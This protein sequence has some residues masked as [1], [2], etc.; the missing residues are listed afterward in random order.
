MATLPF[1]T[2]EEIFK[3]I[4]KLRKDLNPDLDGLT[5]RQMVVI[6]AK[7]EAMEKAEAQ[8]TSASM[9]KTPGK[10]KEFKLDEKMLTAEEREKT[11]K[12][13]ANMKVYSKEIA[14]LNKANEAQKKFSGFAYQYLLRKAV[15]IIDLPAA[16]FKSKFLDMVGRF[17]SQFGI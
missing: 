5:K 1:M 7:L 2:I 6:L 4:T 11:D 15:E 10:R 9:E 16:E 8:I 12:N 17:K 3:K 14:K 13:P